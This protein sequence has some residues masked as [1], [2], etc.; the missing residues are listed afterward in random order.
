MTQTIKELI[1]EVTLKTDIIL[2]QKAATEGN[3]QTLDFIPGNNFLGI[4]AKSYKE[5]NDSLTVFHRNKVRFGDAHPVN[6][7]GERALRIPA[8][9]Y[10]AKMK[11][12]PEILVHHKIPKGKND[13]IHQFEPKQ[14]RSGFYYI[15]NPAE[16]QTPLYKVKA[17]IEKSFAIKSA[18]DR[19]ARR[20]KEGQMYGYESL[21]QDS[22]WRFSVFVDQDVDDKTTE[23]I[24]NK[25]T[26]T[27]TIG[28]SRT[29]QYG[30][31]QI[32]PIGEKD[33]S[34]TPIEGKEYVLVYAD[35]RLIFLDDNGIPTFQPT[36]EDLGFENGQI[37][38]RN[39]QLRFFQ[40]APW[41]G[42]RKARDTD[43]CGIEK[44]SVFFV[45]K[46]ENDMPLAYTGNDFVGY[47]QNEGFGKVIIDP[48]FL[49]TKGDSQIGE[50][51]YFK[52]VEKEE[53][54]KA[55][56]NG[57][58]KTSEDPVFKFL[59]QKQQQE[60]TKTKIYELVNSFK[61]DH[62]KAFSKEVFASQWGTIR[63]M[64]MQGKTDDQILDY[65]SKGVAK[66]KWDENGRRDKLKKFFC[67]IKDEKT[68]LDSE[69]QQ[70]AIINLASEMAKICK[71]GN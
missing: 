4:V 55:K 10:H 16:E 49:A 71:G 59:L 30:L 14:Y 36:A 20:S 22:K 45:E 56:P 27:H 35:A 68:K 48:E 31:I 15:Q 41:N 50:S 51:R 70:S 24:K 39:S 46:K 38:W 57:N 47:Y 29:A 42:Q 7:E 69:A 62:K 11:G 9:F 25:L 43:R 34:S 63:S 44:G 28:R 1:F 52:N 2:N 40:Y 6:E 5:F 58:L 13:Q 12:K 66:D 3:Q 37:D 64:A 67:L 18:Y 26:G 19:E 61:N 17:K 23:K 53:K 65:T 21:L 33:Y 8:S 32:E 60:N 54:E